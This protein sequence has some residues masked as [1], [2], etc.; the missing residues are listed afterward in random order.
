MADEGKPRFEIPWATLLPLVVALAGLIAQFR[1]LVSA[2]PSIP[3]S[4]PIDFTA[5]QDVD[6][7][8][9][10]D[11]LVVAAKAK[12][13]LDSDLLT[14]GVA[15]SRMERH[16]FDA[17]VETVRQEASRNRTTLLAV[18][19]DAGPYIEQEESR[20][21]ARQGVLEGLNESGYVPND[22]E[23]IGFVT[24]PGESSQRWQKPEEKMEDGAILIPWE[25]CRTSAQT[26]PEKT[27]AVFVLW[28]PASSFGDRP[29]EA[30][31]QKIVAPFRRAIARDLDLVLLGPANS[32]GLQ[33]MVREGPPSPGPDN[34]YQ[35][36]DGM[37]IISPRATASDRELTGEDG[38]IGKII[39]SYV[40]GGGLSFERTVLT[41]DKVL[42]ALIAELKLRRVDV[43]D[44]DR[45]VVLTEWDSSYGRSF[46]R[47]FRDKTAGNN[48]VQFY[49]YMHGIDGRL[50]GDAARAPDPSTKS[51]TTQGAAA[52]EATEGVDRSDFLRRLAKELKEQDRRDWRN[53]R[54]G[55]RAIGLLGSDIFDKLMILRALRPEF[56][57]AVF[58][59]NNY[60]A[61]FERKEDWSDVGN[62]VVASPFGG[63]VEPFQTDAR[64]SGDRRFRQRVAPFR[65]TNQTSMFFGTLVATGRV[66]AEM[67]A[68]E[69]ARQPRIFEIGRRGAQELYRP[70]DDNKKSLTADAE[71]KNAQW[72]RRWFKRAGWS[73]ALAVS[74]LFLLAAWISLSIVDRRSADRSDWRD[75]LR[76]LA[77]STTFVLVCGVPAAVFGISFFAQSGGALAEPLAFFSGI[78][79]WPSEMLRLIA[80]LLAIHFMIKAH[81][82][83][84]ANEK[85]IT[86]DFFPDAVLS[87]K[88]RFDLGLRRWQ[89]QYPDWMRGGAK[90]A[91]RDAWQA[92]L[93]RNHFWPRFIRI[94]ALTIM[95]VGFSIGFSRLFPNPAIPARGETAFQADLFVFLIPTVLATIVLTFYVVDA[96]RLTSNLIRV[97][98]FS[99]VKWAPSRTVGSERVPP[100]NPDELARYYD[101]TFIERR[102]QKVAGLIWYPL[103]VLAL[104]FIARSSI[105]DHW[106]WPIFLIVIFT[107][108]AAWAF[109]SAMVLNRSAEK[110]RAATIRSLQ[111]ERTRNYNDPVKRQS[112][113]ELIAEVRAV[114]TGAFAP[115]SEQPFIRAILYPSG[116]LGLIAVGQRLL[117][118]F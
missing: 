42:D 7:R 117:D 45:V 50:P 58:F 79:I 110:L 109:G 31:A 101:I 66:T 17:L 44:D 77:T 13:R 107:L 35:A 40:A 91:A 63:T 103:V 75:R 34:P 54:P 57:D 67:L 4:K 70:P 20:L 12:E 3:N 100:L 59:T 93:E 10:Q 114:R 60:D 71:K 15:T 72:F 6:A 37:R 52:T 48:R 26:S 78:S 92:Y 1:P 19:L 21:R 30:L 27:K 102:T 97:L 53:G 104:S 95:Y 2:R 18:M 113:D 51:S 9:W 14:S 108:N 46:A 65:D 33:K 83:L 49:R 28:L 69:I 8:L 80:L 16:T 118:I 98:N 94:G 36:L 86:R 39:S 73:L 41:D 23:H 96:I 68:E 32:T 11:P 85:E 24:I 105:F 22:S 29:L 106:T 43:Q 115:L 64:L 90:F 25:E 99:M 74:G 87:E 56:P 81:F 38:K 82:D 112:L 5:L 88:W 62:L 116:G 76:R 89:K 111:S 61:H 84:R 55:L 47:A